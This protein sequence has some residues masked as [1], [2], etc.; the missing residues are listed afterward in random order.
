MCDSVNIKKA[1][2]IYFFVQ[3]K[4]NKKCVAIIYLNKKKYTDSLC[5][6]VARN[7]IEKKQ[8]III[9]GFG[10]DIWLTYMT[11]RFC[12]ILAFF[13]VFY[14]GITAPPLTFCLVGLGS[15]FF[16]AVNQGFELIRWLKRFI[17]E[18]RVLEG[19]FN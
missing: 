2:E 9:N 8:I 10:I 1:N 11:Y 16:V 17:K 6:N 5:Y 3:K 4:W 12:F 14:S 13:L 15:Q 18:K 7:W 19:T